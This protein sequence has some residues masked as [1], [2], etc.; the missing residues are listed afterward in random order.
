MV[1]HYSTFVQEEDIAQIA[2]AGLNWIRLPIPFWAI[3]T[4]SDVGVDSDSTT[5]VAEPFL[6]KV[7][8]EYILQILSWCRK[9]G[10]RVNLDLHAVPGSQNG[11]SFTLLMI[12]LLADAIDSQLGY[13]HSGKVGQI[14]FMNGIM[15]YANAQ[16]TL[17]YIRTITEFV[18]QAE[19]LDLVPMFSIVNE[20]L[21][22][23]I[24]KEQMTSLYVLSCPPVPPSL[25]G[26]SIS[27]LQAHDMIRSITG[28]GEGNG[29]FI[30]IHDGFQSL[31]SWSGFLQGSDRIAIGKPR[32]TFD[33]SLCVYVLFR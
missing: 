11:L 33:N 32:V 23:T 28:V 20:A 10:I 16:R 5:P 24:G 4:W 19:Y 21:L 7:C 22:N 13:N 6:A 2:G 8:W 27:Y 17:D 29:P 25:I 3:E 30:T 9:Y 12:Y 1:E 15:G 18:T 26:F 31:G 14:N